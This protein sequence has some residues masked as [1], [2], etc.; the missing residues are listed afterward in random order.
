MKQVKEILERRANRRSF[1]KNSMVAGAV[2]TVGAGILGKGLPAFASETSSGALTKGDIAILQFL[3]AAEPDGA[4][5]RRVGLGDAEV[6]GP[7]QQ[8]RLVRGLEQQAV[9][10]FDELS[11]QIQ[12]LC[13]AVFPRLLGIGAHGGVVAVDG[14]EGCDLEP[15][16]Q[17]FRLR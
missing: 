17:K 1:L 16:G 12:I 13:S 5:R 2:A 10:G 3:A 4:D 7:H 14:V 8:H 6:V 9:A 15:L 11:A